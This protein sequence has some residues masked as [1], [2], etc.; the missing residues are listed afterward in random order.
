MEVTQVT[1]S[2]I[3]HKINHPYH[4]LGVSNLKLAMGSLVAQSVE[5]FSHGC[6]FDPCR[7]D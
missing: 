7:G 6:R 5:R 2:G 3:R 1:A 4:C